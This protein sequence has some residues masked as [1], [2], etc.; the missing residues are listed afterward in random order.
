MFF[1][2]LWNL[3][4][5]L[6]LSVLFHHILITFQ[7]FISILIAEFIWDYHVKGKLVFE[8]ETGRK[9]KFPVLLMLPI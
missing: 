3:D 8:Q 7:M 9:C 5:R 4:I 6:S 1:G 2:Q